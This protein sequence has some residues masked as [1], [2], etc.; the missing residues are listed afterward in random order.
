MSRQH[1]AIWRA[2]RRTRP[3]V[4]IAAAAVVAAGL[5]ARVFALDEQEP[6]EPRAGAGALPVATILVR[7]QD[8]YTETVAFTGRVRAPAVSRLG[9]EQAGRIVTIPVREGDRFA[10][11]DVLARLDDARLK[12][13]E[14]RIRA[15]LAEAEAE[16]DLAAATAERERALFKAGH[17]SRQ[18][19]DEAEARLK[20]AAA[21]AAGAKADLARIRVA[22]AQTRIVAPFAGVVTARLVDEGTVVA[23]GTPVLA[24]LAS[25]GAGELLVGLPEA[26]GRGLV[27]GRPYPVR[28]EDGREIRAR[29]AGL[30]PQLQPRSRALVARLELPAGIAVADGALAS[31]L[32]ERRVPVRGFWL[33][34]DALTADLRGLWRVYALEEDPERGWPHA[35]VHFENVQILHAAGERAYVTGTVP[36]GTRVIATGLHR[37]VP[38]MLVRVEEPEAPGGGADARAES[39]HPPGKRLAE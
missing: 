36:D 16:R 33:P 34:L 20:A 15:A 13:E 39:L 3:A 2:G 4:W 19:L 25:D 18:R 37:V 38:G 7:Y 35:R 5:L 14:D 9:F 10:K 24:V 12:A 17:V 27:P 31:L 28:L 30:V 11:G 29:L 32:V 1:G 23:A 21:A 22:L 6:E 26:D 8:S